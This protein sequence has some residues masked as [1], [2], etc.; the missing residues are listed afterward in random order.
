MNARCV[1]IVA[2]HQLW[3]WYI[4]K[5]SMLSEISKKHHQLIFLNILKFF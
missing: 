4:V 1:G 5:K 2:R 3:T